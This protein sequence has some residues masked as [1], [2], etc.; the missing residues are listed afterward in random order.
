MTRAPKHNLFT[1]T[2]VHT[3]LLDA[4]GEPIPVRTVDV[5]ALP[6][7]E[8]DALPGLSDVMGF[9]DQIEARLMGGEEP[10]IILWHPGS[11]LHIEMPLLDRRNVATYA[12]ALLSAVSRQAMGEAPEGGGYRVRAG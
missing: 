8:P 10:V 11:D 7:I 6:K 4:N 2:A 5:R 12:K 9:P 3:G 1:T